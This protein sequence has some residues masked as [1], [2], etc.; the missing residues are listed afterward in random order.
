MDEKKLDNSITLHLNYG[1]EGKT[2]T[3]NLE[4]LTDEQL[5]DLYDSGLEQARYVLRERTGSDPAVDILNMTPEDVDWHVDWLKR[6]GKYDE[7]VAA[8]ND[9]A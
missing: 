7:Y 2:V 4:D 5:S 6:H 3:A 8:G 1:T 9:R